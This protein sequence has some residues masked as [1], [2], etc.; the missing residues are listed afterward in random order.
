[1]RDK[2]SETVTNHGTPNLIYKS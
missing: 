2:K 1:M